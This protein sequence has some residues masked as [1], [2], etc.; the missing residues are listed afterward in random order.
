MELKFKLGDYINISLDDEDDETGSIIG[1]IKNSTPDILIDQEDKVY[2]IWLEGT[3]TVLPELGVT[4][5]YGLSRL[6]TLETGDYEPDFDVIVLYDSDTGEELYYEVN[7]G[8]KECV[9]NYCNLIGQHKTEEEIEDLTCIFQPRGEPFL[10]EKVLK[11]VD[12]EEDYINRD[13]K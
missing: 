7:D 10:R 3:S 13:S 8:L 9:Y 4:A 5:Y 1:L 12:I 11:G 2:Q 6:F